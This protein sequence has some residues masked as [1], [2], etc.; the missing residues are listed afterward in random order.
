MRV[1][2]LVSGGVPWSLDIACSWSRAGDRVTVVLLDG[3]A[4]SVRRHHDHEPAVRA[5]LQAGVTVLAHDTAL[6][7]RA[8]QTDALLEGVEPVDLDAVAD[9]VTTGADKAVWW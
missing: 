3:A 9:L 2:V 5:A 8:L 6:R 7:R 4:A 1:T